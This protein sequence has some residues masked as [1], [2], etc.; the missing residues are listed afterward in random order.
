MTDDMSLSQ[1]RDELR[2]V[3]RFDVSELPANPLNAAVQKIKDNPACGPARLLARMLKALTYESGEFRRAEASAFDRTTL[4]LAI[5]LMN[6]ARTGGEV[7]PCA[8]HA[9]AHG[10]DENVPHRAWVASHAAIRYVARCDIAFDRAS[11]LRL[12]PILTAEQP[13]GPRNG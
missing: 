8:R 9:M 13:C 5:A 12:N 7:R 6:A 4:R 10:V 3:G 11:H 2:R 1:F